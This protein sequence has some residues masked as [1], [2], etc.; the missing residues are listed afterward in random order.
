MYM[1]SKK[2]KTFDRYDKEKIKKEIGSAYAFGRAGNEKNEAII[3]LRAKVAADIA[4][5]ERV[6]MLF[7]HVD[8]N[9]GMYKHIRDHLNQDRKWLGHYDKL[10]EQTKKGFE[11]LNIDAK[12]LIENAFKDGE[13][14]AEK[15][16]VLRLTAER[17]KQQGNKNE[18]NN[19]KN[20]NN[21]Q[22]NNHD[23][24]KRQTIVVDK[25][26]V[27]E[28]DTGKKG[29]KNKDKGPKFQQVKH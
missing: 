17:A 20:R 28:L 7:T 8:G 21:G 4:A 15:A 24:N 3:A 6:V 25:M 23:N 16:L 22:H 2:Y 18:Q 27:K 9:D 26:Y 12:A 14:S 29:K 13:I 11:Q 1:F 10:L 5:Q 19:D